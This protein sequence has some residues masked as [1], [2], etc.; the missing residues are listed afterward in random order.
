[1]ESKRIFEGKKIAI[2]TGGGDTAA[3]NASIEAIKARVSILGFKVY[4]IIE[5]WQ[6]LL[7]DGNI[8][9][10]T[11]QPYDGWYGGTALKSSRTNP[12]PTKNN[13]IDRTEQIIRNIKRYEIDV[14]VTIGGD[15]TNGAAK[16]LYEKYGIPVVG[17]PKTI[18]NDLRTKTMHN[19]NG[20]ELEAVM[21]PGFPSAA[22]GVS[23]YTA[24]LCT[25]AESHSRVIVLEIM[26]RDAGWLTGSASFGGADISLIP[27]YD[28]TKERK[29]DFFKRVKDVYNNSKKGYVIVAVSEGVRWYDDEKEELGMVYASSEVDE[30]GHPRFGGISG[31]IASE[32]A[33]ETGIQAR[34]ESTGYYARSGNCRKYDKR[35]VN[36]LADKLLDILLREDYGKMPVL[37]RLSSYQ[38]IEEYN[39]GTIDMGDIGNMPLN[40]A[41]YD[42]ESF[43]FNEKYFDF[44]SYFLS[45]PKGIY[46]DYN[47]PKVKPIEI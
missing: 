46:F 21:C 28:I 17:F 10:L 23:E 3:L 40:P 18:D 32:I 16:K 13:P 37:A 5:G 35:L 27:E 39:T 41:Y 34:A 31:V 19:Y 8:V 15:D 36:V 6:G 47:F 14:L 24:R 33:K 11:G 4:G 12:F 1:M 29:A 44:L 38:E 25:T 45:R 26:G 2:L 20:T 9:N 30:F 42:K 43:Q 7:G 22:K